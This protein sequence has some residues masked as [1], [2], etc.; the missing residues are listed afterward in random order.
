M[1]IK[2]SLGKKFAANSQAVTYTQTGVEIKDLSCNRAEDLRYFPRVFYPACREP[3]LRRLIADNVLRFT[4]ENSGMA[5]FG[6]RPIVF[7]VVCGKY[8]QFP[9]I[10]GVGK[11]H[12]KHPYGTGKNRQSEWQ[13]KA[14][15]VVLPPAMR[16]TSARAADATF[17]TAITRPVLQETFG[18]ITAGIE[19]CA[20][21]PFSSQALLLCCPVP[22]AAKQTPGSRIA[23]SRLK[24]STHPCRAC[25][26]G[27][28][29]RATTKPR[30]VTPHVGPSISRGTMFS[31]PGVAVQAVSWRRRSTKRQAA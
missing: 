27:M 23:P 4:R 13:S 20:F 6:Y 16:W 8:A 31:P 24:T 30:F 21:I 12:G 10:T 1:E 7:V 2:L 19:P 14:T 9:L 26:T 3:P 11:L 28:P 15:N 18:N 17:A 22:H 5:A 25:N 29:S